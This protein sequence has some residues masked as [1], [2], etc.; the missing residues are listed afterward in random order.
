MLDRYFVWMV[1]GLTGDNQD[2]GQPVQ[3]KAGEV[4]VKD[5]GLWIGDTSQR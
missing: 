5:S 3:R 4:G 1:S 2:G